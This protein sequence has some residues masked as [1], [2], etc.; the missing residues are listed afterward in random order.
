MAERPH[1]GPAAPRLP[2][3]VVPGSGSDLA[4]HGRA[5]GAPRKIRSIANRADHARRLANELSAAQEEAQRKQAE[6]EE[7]VRADGLVLTVEGWSDEPDYE[8]ALKSLDTYGASLLSV[9]PASAELPER[10]VLWIPYAVIS[11]FF[12]RIEDFAEKE[13]PRGRPATGQTPPATPGT[14]AAE[15]GPG[16][17]AARHWLGEAEHA[18][19]SVSASCVSPPRSKDRTPI[20][21]GLR[22]R[23]F[24][25]WRGP[26]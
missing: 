16:M 19:L 21:P 22:S 2:H 5:G 23:L 3:L 25:R 9:L 10:A 26:G 4:Y 11:K 7:D 6:T 15:A 8:L 12:R 18:R 14:R 1:E 20:A 17:F 13:T 24:R